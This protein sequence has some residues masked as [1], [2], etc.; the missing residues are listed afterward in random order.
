MNDTWKR[1]DIIIMLT[2]SK[3][4]S[5]ISQKIVIDNGRK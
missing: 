4:I 3:N 2:D 5:N 1:W